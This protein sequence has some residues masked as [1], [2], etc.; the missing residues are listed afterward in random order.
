MPPEDTSPY[1]TSY[2]DS[3]DVSET[4]GSPSSLPSSNAA[5]S[6]PSA[7]NTPL[8]MR[9][10]DRGRGG[11]GGFS[12]SGESGASGLSASGAQADVDRLVREGLRSLETQRR[13]LQRE[14]EQLERR[15]ARLDAEMK[16]SFSGASQDI[17]RKSVV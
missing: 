15:K 7:S 5:S 10:S 12:T 1:D 11:S 14:V 2:E 16:E 6:D 3:A 4:S 8:G 17:D 13:D 9:R